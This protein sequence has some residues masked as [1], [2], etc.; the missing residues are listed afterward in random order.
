MQVKQAVHRR[1]GSG[2][3]YTCMCARG[4]AV[5]L[6]ALIACAV[7]WQGMNP[8][9][10]IADE[11]VAL[12]KAESLAVESEPTSETM[13]AEAM[14]PLYS[15][16]SLSL[17]ED[18]LVVQDTQ[19]EPAELEEIPAGEYGGFLFRLSDDAVQDPA[20]QSRLE[21]A[22][23]AGA[24]RE[25]SQG[26]YAVDSLDDL[27]SIV[28][29]SWLDYIEPDYRMHLIGDVDGQA[30]TASAAA[31]TGGNL[32][33]QGGTTANPAPDYPPTDPEYVSGALWNLD[34]LNVQNA[35]EAGLDGDPYEYNG[36]PLR[37]SNVRV[38]VI[39][40]GLYGTGTT[41]EQHEDLDYTKMFSGTNFVTSDEGTPDA[42]GHGTFVAGLI[43][44]QVNNGVGVAG[45]QPGV[46]IVSEKVFDTGSASTEDVISAIYAAVDKDGADVINMSLGGEYNERS[47][48]TACDYAVSKGVLVVASAGNDG[49]S[50]PNYPAA[51]DSVVGVASVNSGRQRS[52]W[53]QYGKSVFVTAPGE[54][55]TSTFMGASDA[56]KT[57]SG[58]SFSGPE[59]AALAAMCKSVYPDI[60][61]DTFKQML[62]ETSTDLGAKGYD[63][64]Y[65]W[66]L[67]DF[68][69]MAEAVLASQVMP[70]YHISFDLA[71]EN[72]LPVSVSNASI[73]LTAAEDIGWEADPD[74]GIDAA[75][76][77]PEGTQVTQKSDGTFDVHR[78]NYAYIV[79]VD[80][81][82]AA[83]GT[84]KTYA[85]NQRILLT[86]PTAYAVTVKVVDGQGAAVD[87]ADLSV[88]AQGGRTEIPKS[89]NASST[90]YDLASGQY[91][92]E[93]SATGYEPGAG[94]FTVQR[95]D[96]TI[97]AVLYRSNELATVTYSVVDAETS[98]PVPGA[99]VSVT[100]ASGVTIAPQDDG[101]YRLAKGATYT[102]AAT[103]AGYENS[104]VSFT[105][106]TGSEDSFT[107]GMLRAANRITFNVIDGEGKAITTAVVK[108]ANS[109]GDTVEPLES[110]KLQFGLVEGDYTY[111][112]SAP[113]YKAKTG[114]FG[115][116]LDSYTITV[117]LEAV[118]HTV[119]FAVTDSSTGAA[120]S[121]YTVKVNLAD[122]LRA[123]E[124]SAPNTYLLTPADYNYTIYKAGYKIAAGSF[125]V[126]GEDLVIPVALEQ[127]GQGVGY[128]GGSGTQD[129]PYL[130]ATEDQLRY[131]AQQTEIVRATNS[132]APTN[133]KEIVSGY[134]R[135]VN[136]IELV[137]G[138]WLPI[139]NAESSSNYVAF[140]GE[141]DG[142]GHTV[143]GISITGINYDYQ[144]FFGYVRGANIHDLTVAGTIDVDG[145]SASS[146]GQYIGGL[147]G[148][149]YYANDP[150]YTSN[151]CGPTTI[152]RCG[153]HVDVTG[154]Y[155]VGGIVGSATGSIPSTGSPIGTV[156]EFGITVRDCYNKG[157]IHGMLNGS[158]LRATGV[159]FTAAG[160]RTAGIVGSAQ[161]TDIEN[162]YNMGEVQTGSMAGGIAGYIAYSK[163]NACYASGMAFQHSNSS[164][165]G[166]M[167]GSAVGSALQTIVTNAYG[168]NR[169]DNY[170]NVVY[171]DATRCEI[172]DTAMFDRAAMYRNDAFVATMNEAAGADATSIFLLGND[173]PLLYWE[174]DPAAT[175]AP[176][177]YIIVQPIGN[178]ELTAYVQGSQAA[179]LSASIEEIAIEDGIVSWQW[180]ASETPNFRD[181]V[182]A[183]GGFG[184]GMQAT[185]TPSTETAGLTYYFC[186]FTNRL[187]FDLNANESSAVSEPASIYVRTPEKA[188]EAVITQLNPS[189][190]NPVNLSLNAKQGTD[191][192]LSVTA[193]VDDGG[194]LTYQ[195]YSST[196]GSGAG[197]AI[198]GATQTVYSVD[199]AT[200]G[201]AYYYV[202]VTN[203]TGPGNATKKL[204]DWI[205]VTVDPYTISNYQELASFRTA[206][207]SGN[208]FAGNIVYLL[209]DIEIPGGVDWTPI[210]TSESPFMGTFMGGSGYA[211][212][213]PA[214]ISVHKI[215]N[216]NIDGNAHGN[217]YL[218]LFGYVYGGSICD[219]RVGGVVT[220]AS[221][222]DTGLLVGLITL[223][224]GTAASIENC[225]TLPGSTVEGAYSLGGIAGYCAASISNCANHADINA[226]AYV[227]SLG[228]GTVVADHM[229]AVGGVSGYQ[230]N[231][232][233][234][235]CYNTGTIT[236]DS[237][238]ANDGTVC[239]TL[240]T[241]PAWHRASMRAGCIWGPLQRANTSAEYSTLARWPAI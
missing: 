232:F 3:A 2:S 220:G 217:K 95:S 39:D 26:M 215:T 98:T 130:I 28:D 236:V 20:A 25:L 179:V 24:V 182:A 235:G 117:M 41:E 111:E 141:F 100:D 149:V 166:G 101:T 132:T 187:G 165:D 162:C 16:K 224:G 211:G 13:S 65:G 124:Q 202:E 170:S 209:D 29:S 51:Y 34:M 6:A 196:T 206:V 54:N 57:A 205:T 218:G 74:N 192:Q 18:V 86:L 127:Q 91:S 168:L 227:G 113:G 84:F 56:Y 27:S 61:Q 106:G 75:G 191:L 108:V 142:D 85:E 99:T 92:Y 80:G 173:Y 22:A 8:A 118:P 129:D 66:G 154:R 77:W 180:Y 152:E 183:P 198:E 114:S 138:E 35:W 201:T 167:T 194:T 52:T 188:H 239:A 120:I 212:S 69:K 58:T 78:G 50:T 83:S 55:V 150:I 169:D 90:T 140:G 197:K 199:T 109:L 102:G 148:G 195:W 161:Y 103:K 238:S 67:V 193:T 126:A 60:D 82:Y 203:T 207:N 48:E 233:A 70:W 64:F 143:S 221:N 174:V 46:E 175:L 200:L 229:Y 226:R 160:R 53:S 14:T 1:K 110:N 37:D 76:N 23:K 112:A 107:V 171:A 31:K 121:D 156:S 21:D 128:A 172:S 144:G 208:T 32:D 45:A 72:G 79:A 237:P 115:V 15:P 44:A 145:K 225:A 62:I 230:N 210:G 47:L 216:L 146:G 147:V 133:K 159:G 155:A 134:F 17:F 5:V 96:R 40:T 241:I 223:N 176:T 104:T 36:K 234:L 136:D 137:Q 119:S 219:V 231:G 204:S 131:L 213:D 42:H 97:N 93:A 71:D 228:S 49:V 7:A 125:T 163:V 181:A 214:A 33:V 139:G 185:Y 157:V 105:V 63:D 19:G 12:S 68:G 81:Y 186:V 9:Q 87:G 11:G 94:N 184:S 153:N 122:R 88:T 177:P 178:T 89:S 30:S 73:T 190:A 151:N 123:I 116:A 189:G 4:S 10:T 43:A 158:Y 59:V 135:L 38:A 240:P 222:T 164:G